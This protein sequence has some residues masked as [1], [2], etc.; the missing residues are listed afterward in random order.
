MSVNNFD[1]NN[2]S[3]TPGRPEGNESVN[4]GSSAVDLAQKENLEKAIEIARTTKVLD[5]TRE[6]LDTEDLKRLSTRFVLVNELIDFTE[7][8]SMLAF[9]GNPGDIWKGNPIV[10]LSDLDDSEIWIHPRNSNIDLQDGIDPNTGIEWKL[11]GQDKMCSVAFAEESGL[12]VNK[13]DETV[14]DAF[15][16]N[17]KL[18]DVTLTKLKASGKKLTDYIG[19]VKRSVK[20]SR[21][22]VS[23]RNST[24]TVNQSQSKSQSQNKNKALMDLLLNSFGID[25][26]KRFLR[27]V[28]GDDICKSVNFSSSPANATFD[29]VDYLDRNGH[30][31]GTSFW[32]AFVSERPRRRLE[33]ANVAQLYGILI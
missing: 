12:L 28:I 26:M 23:S 1:Y 6:L 3:G 13:D 27:Y 10:N 30:A 16:K 31:N 9:K 18:Y 14:F 32:N 8:K 24:V 17:G 29:A 25:E 21:K 33:I 19:C 15:A 5:L 7:T 20:D 22:N 2:G 4:S 11:L